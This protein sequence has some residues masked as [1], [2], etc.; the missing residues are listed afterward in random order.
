MDEEERDILNNGLLNYQRHNTDVR[1][2]DLVDF[3]LINSNIEELPE[4]SRQ[5]RVR[6]LSEYV[7]AKLGNHFGL[8][9]LIPSNAP[10]RLMSARAHDHGDFHFLD[11]DAVQG[12]PQYM[13]SALGTPFGH[14]IV[15]N[16]DELLDEIDQEIAHHYPSPPN[17]AVKAEC[18]EFDDSLNAQDFTLID[19]ALE[20][21]TPSSLFDEGD[22]IVI[23]GSESPSNTSVLSDSDS[24]PLPKGATLLSRSSISVDKFR[25]IM[26]KSP[27]VYQVESIINDIKD[28]S[29]EFIKLTEISS[30]HKMEFLRSVS[31]AESVV[32]D[33]SELSE[34][35]VS[36]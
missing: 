26:S 27:K 14:D 29:G 33:E 22:M 13:S 12:M 8:D 15:E 28:D 35:G 9:I 2:S 10:S 34:F 19:K 11:N 20:Q 1:G 16:M 23:D 7:S 30:Y 31:F 21:D 5:N 36:Q 32:E 17:I 18:M 3:L 6:E 24:E 4:E 25:A